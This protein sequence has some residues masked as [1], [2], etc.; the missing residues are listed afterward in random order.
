M[1]DVDE[2]GGIE[3]MTRQPTYLGATVN[4]VAVAEKL[5]TVWYGEIDLFLFRNVRKDKRTRRVG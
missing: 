5:N 1:K 4:A 2:G 3:A